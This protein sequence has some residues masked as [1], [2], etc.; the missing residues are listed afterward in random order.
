MGKHRNRLSQSQAP[1]GGSLSIQLPLPV[2][3]LFIDTRE[4][5]HELCIKTG[6]EVLVAMMEAD[7]EGL[8]GPKGVHQPG[9]RAWRGGSTAGRVTLGGR[10]IEMPRL[11]ARSAEGELSLASF[12]WAASRDPLNAHTMEAIG[13]GVSTRKYHRTLDPLP[14]GM[15]EHATSRAALSANMTETP[16]PLG[17]TVGR[18][19]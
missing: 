7:R 2:L 18:G 1:N 12:S 19:R 9:R 5:F 10:Q 14:F 16:A 3:G 17:I 11:R 4:A 8:C 15:V 13:A 6:R